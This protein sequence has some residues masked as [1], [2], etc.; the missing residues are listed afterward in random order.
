MIAAHFLQVMPGAKRFA[1]AGQHHD[2]HAAVGGDL[3]DRGDQALQHG[4]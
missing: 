2:A 1:R 3:I 4:A